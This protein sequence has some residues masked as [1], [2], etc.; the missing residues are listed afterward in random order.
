[1]ALAFCSIAQCFM[2]QL[3]L[4]SDSGAPCQLIWASASRSRGAA[5]SLDPAAGNR[6]GVLD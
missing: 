2:T 3:T 4:S 5:F 6:F 1:M